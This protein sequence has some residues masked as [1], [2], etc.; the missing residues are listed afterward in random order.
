MLRSRRR[1]NAGP[2][3]F[4]DRPPPAAGFTMAKNRSFNVANLPVVADRK[5]S[6]WL[7]GVDSFD[8][9]QTFRQ[10]IAFDLHGGSA[11]K[12]LVQQNDSVHALV[13]QQSTVAKHDVA[14]QIFRERLALLQM[15]HQDELFTHHRPLRPD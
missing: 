10:R 4:A 6:Q 15:D 3:S 11:R 5:S 1:A 12:V 9:S 2:A 8:S 14:P 13:I 7:N